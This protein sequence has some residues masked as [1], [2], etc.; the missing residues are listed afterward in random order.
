MGK[1]ITFISGCRKNEEKKEKKKTIEEIKR[2]R[3]W[4]IMVNWQEMERE[5]PNKMR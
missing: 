3:R 4:G 2:R 5:T 1:Y